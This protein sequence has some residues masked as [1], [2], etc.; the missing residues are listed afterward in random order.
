M[1]LLNLSQNALEELPPSLFDGLNLSVIDLSHNNLRKLDSQLFDLENLTSLDVSHNKLQALPPKVFQSGVSKLEILDLAENELSTL[2]ALFFCCNLSIRSLKLEGNRLQ[3]L[4]SGDFRGLS[5]LE[6]LNLQQN[7]LAHLDGAV[8][9]D[10]EH[11]NLKRSLLKLNLGGNQLA[12]L[13]NDLFNGFRALRNLQLQ[14][15]LL[16]RLPQQLFQTLGEVHWTFLGFLK[17][18][19][20]I[21]FIQQT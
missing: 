11:H 8:F 17:E 4:H 1:K 9:D 21:R 2:P 3:R 15:N 20:S 16:A 12:T 6:E 13:P 7:Q 5:Y 18:Y 10:Y 14:S 19:D